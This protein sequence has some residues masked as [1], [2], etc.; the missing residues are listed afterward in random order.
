[1][2]NLLH[3]KLSSQIPTSSSPQVIIVY[4]FVVLFFR[5]CLVR[6]FVIKK[7]ELKTEFIS[8]FRSHNLR[9]HGHRH[10]RTFLTHLD[11]GQHE[12]VNRAAGSRLPACFDFLSHRNELVRTSGP[13]HGPV[14]GSTA[15]TYYNRHLSDLCE[16]Q[17][18]KVY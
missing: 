17:R 2:Q 12:F 14:V 6:F 1:M 8:F 16:Y 4:Y 9:Q 5:R 13:S 10:V 3:S 11:D 18:I 15:G 7:R